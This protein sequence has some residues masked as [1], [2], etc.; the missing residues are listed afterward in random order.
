M[1]SK[2]QCP[3]NLGS[4]NCFV[5]QTTIEDKPFES[6][7]CFDCGITTNSYFA[8]DSEKLEKLTENNTAL[9]NDLKIIDEERGLVW[10][11]SVL[12]M[13]ER[14]I[15]YPDGKVND[16]YWNYAKVIDVP[17]NEREK[18]D[19]HDKRLDL[20]NA[21]KFGQFEFMDACK[22]MGIILEGEAEIPVKIQ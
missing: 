8:I 12:N 20:E 15:I 4:K 5:E 9:M 18:Y 16:W 2:T 17:E 11:P 3:C 13:G 7:M 1:E 6:Y 10:Y 22:A 19:G 14:G 21:E